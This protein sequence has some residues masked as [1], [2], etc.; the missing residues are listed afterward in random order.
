MSPRL[1]NILIIVIFVAISA[2]LMG[3]CGRKGEPATPE[4]AAETE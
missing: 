4:P 3:S 1:R 2:A